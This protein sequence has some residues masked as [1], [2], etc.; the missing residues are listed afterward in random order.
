MDNKVESQQVVE[1]IK[2]HKVRPNKDL[3]K[4]MDL[5][6]QDFEYTKNTVINLTK[7]LDKLENTYN[8]ILKE[9][10]SRIGK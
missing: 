3:I 5:I 8:Q 4:A 9:Y 2:E 6:T 10:N 1:I 7:H